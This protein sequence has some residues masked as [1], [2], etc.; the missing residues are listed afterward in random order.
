MPGGGYQAKTSDQDDERIEEF[1][2][3]ISKDEEEALCFLELNLEEVDITI[4]IIVDWT[5]Q[6]FPVRISR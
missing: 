6:V 3:K 5:Q 4:I 1:K 2:E